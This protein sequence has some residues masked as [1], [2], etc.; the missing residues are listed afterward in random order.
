METLIKY[1]RCASYKY[2]SPDESK[3]QETGKN[4]ISAES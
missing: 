1:D 3:N 4:I 2:Q